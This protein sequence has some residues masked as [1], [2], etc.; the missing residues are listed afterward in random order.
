MSLS[1]QEITG[2]SQEEDGRGPTPVTQGLYNPV[3]GKRTGFGRQKRLIE[4][5]SSLGP[6][7]EMTSQQLKAGGESTSEGGLGEKGSQNR[8]QGKGS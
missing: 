6:E 1:G 8:P 7:Q 5:E 2:L 4:S 3:T